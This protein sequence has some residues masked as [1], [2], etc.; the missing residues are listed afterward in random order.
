MLVH[1]TPQTDGTQQAKHAEAQAVPEAKT[2]VWEEFREA[3]E[4]ALGSALKKFWQ[5]VL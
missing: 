4:N 2:R 5:T 3:M 1:G